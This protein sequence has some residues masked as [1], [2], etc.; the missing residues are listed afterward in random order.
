M[1][2]FETGNTKK[3]CKTAQRDAG[4][5][6]RKW[7]QVN[8]GVRDIQSMG[9]EGTSTE[10]ANIEKFFGYK[11]TIP[12][13]ITLFNR[14]E[15]YEA[16]VTNGGDSSVVTDIYAIITHPPKSAHAKIIAYQEL[17]RRAAVRILALEDLKDTMLLEIERHESNV[18]ERSRKRWTPED[19]ELLIE[20][21]SQDD[22]TIFGM[23]KQFGRTPG[24]IQSRISYLVGIKRVSEEIAGR[25]IGTLNGEF[26][27]G[28]IDGIVSKGR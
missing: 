3:E 24:A 16:L 2:L 28:D 21:A 20:T 12:D 22:A 1:A 4:I 11:D 6:H 8:H 25:F 23:A 19:D 10:V 27:E 17:L 13:Y 15:M 9:F 26:V 7:S 5:R 14:D 18:G